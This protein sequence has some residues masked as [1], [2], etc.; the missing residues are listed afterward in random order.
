[1]RARHAEL[2]PGLE[3]L[4]Q[5]RDAI[6]TG[7]VRRVIEL[8]E[9]VSGKF[10][11]YFAELGYNGEVTLSRTDETDFKSYGVAIKVVVGLNTF[12]QNYQIQF[13]NSQTQVRFRAGEEWSELAKG[14][15]SGGEMSVTTAVYMLSLQVQQGALQYRP[16]L[17][18]V[19]S[20]GV[21]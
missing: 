21:K 12:F 11:D 4:G 9:K 8:I 14:R 18:P 15:Q 13:E 20:D 5:E 3:A 6:F 17:L 19:L 2:V 7:G 1:V 10:G 16:Y